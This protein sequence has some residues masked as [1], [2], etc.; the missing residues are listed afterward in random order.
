[1]IGGRHSLQGR[2]PGERRV[3]VERP[4]WPYFR[5]T[6]KGQLTAT[7]PIAAVDDRTRPTTVVALLTTTES[8]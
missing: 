5:D 7:Y 3:R 4:H 1:V 2:K 8:R 6:D